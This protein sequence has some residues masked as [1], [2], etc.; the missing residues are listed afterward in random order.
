MKETLIVIA[1]IA[2]TALAIYKVN[3][4]AELKARI[5]SIQ[6]HSDT[7]FIEGKKDTILIPKTSYAK[8]KVPIKPN[9]DTTL[10]LENH[11]VKVKLDS[12][13]N[14]DIECKKPE[15]I[16]TQ[17]DTIKLFIPKIVEVEKPRVWYDKFWVGY[18]TGVAVT[19]GTFYL[20]TK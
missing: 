19:L 9:I 13:I 7:I 3:E 15:I 8:I 4:V 10:N 11:L 6:A 20:F 12:L 17:R 14:V 16:I 2:I 1:F 5:S 18:I